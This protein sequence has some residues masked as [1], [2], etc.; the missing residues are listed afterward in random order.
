LL[1]KDV[2]ISTHNTRRKD[3]KASVPKQKVLVNKTKRTRGRRWVQ[4][5]FRPVIKKTKSHHFRRNGPLRGAAILK[6]PGEKERFLERKLQSVE[7]GRRG[8][9]ERKRSFA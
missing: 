5:L 8:T 3:S 6:E 1:S 4:R 9:T 2:L 7:E